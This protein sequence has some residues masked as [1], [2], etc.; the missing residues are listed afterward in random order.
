MQE[1]DSPKVY[2]PLMPE[3]LLQG[4][5]FYPL[6]GQILFWHEEWQQYVITLISEDKQYTKQD[7]LQLPEGAPY[8]L[9]HGKLVFMPSP[10][11]QHQRISRKLTFELELFLRE[12]PQGE[13][14]TA[15]ID[16]HFDEEN[17][18]QPDLLFVSIKRSNII[19]KWIMGA[20][21]FV[22]EI[23]SLST[24]QADRTQKMET[25]GKHN[26]LEYWLINPQQEEVEVY[27]NHNRQMQ[28]HQTA[29]KEDT[30]TSKA[31][32]G[33]ELAVKRI[34]NKIPAS[35]QDAQCIFCPEGTKGL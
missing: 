10:F 16:V 31:I 8:Q 34:L 32:E 4:K 33:L 21:D 14:F 30:I 26:V 35:I 7:Y 15:P 6:N 29:G 5:L 2:I 9:I 17:I 22:V 20:P 1:T 3:K 24:E 19:Q 13:T 18:F 11:T 23:V 25:Y 27:H 28:H 12:N